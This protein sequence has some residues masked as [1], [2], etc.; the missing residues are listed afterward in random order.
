MNVEASIP[1][2][3]QKAYE[4]LK[5]SDAIAAQS[6]L[7]EA[8]E[9]DYEY[10]E[11]IYA[12]KCVKWWRERLE[13]LGD[14]HGD[15]DK[16]GF[17]LSQWK[18]FYSFLDRIG[19]DHEACLYAI[20]IF[21]FSTALQYFQDVLGDGTNQHDPALLLQVG[22][23]YK[24]VGQYDLAVKYLEQAH[25]FKREDG[26]TLSEL[27]D[28][29]ALLEETKVAKALFREAFFV[30]PLGVDLRSMESALIITLR[31]QVRDLGLAGDALKEWIP[32]YGV[33][34]GVFSVKR[35]LKPVEV[36]K[37]R[38]SIFSLENEVRSRPE[39]AALRIPRLINRYLW[40]IDHYENVREDPGLIEETMLKIKIIDPAMYERIR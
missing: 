27:A 33:I 23:C 24:G 7:D 19:E 14:F 16:G 40:L 26:E 12:L 9:I 13:R 2:L 18:S 28:V 1:G 21:I 17:I 6:A 30:D 31:D 20:R 34:F 35:K 22:R 15:Y 10:P 3:I 25:R 32:V 11:T 37:L 38:Q 8:L 5:A 36:G 4:Y 29:N 39:N